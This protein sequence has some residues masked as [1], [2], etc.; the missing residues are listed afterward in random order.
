MRELLEHGDLLRIFNSKYF[1]YSVWSFRKRIWAKT[2]QLEDVVMM[3][4]YRKYLEVRL[5]NFEFIISL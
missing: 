4:K 2:E 5:F 3:S 1:S